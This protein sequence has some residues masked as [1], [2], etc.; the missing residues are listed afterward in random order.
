MRFEPVPVVSAWQ[1]PLQGWI[2]NVYGAVGVVMGTA[3]GLLRFW[4][5]DPDM[6]ADMIPVDTAINMTL[7]A[8]WEV[9]TN[10]TQ[11]LVLQ[12]SHRFSYVNHSNV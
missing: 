6:V 4:C 3:L 9:A 8:T 5:A 11:M 2:N 7:A 12:L 10:K 1:E